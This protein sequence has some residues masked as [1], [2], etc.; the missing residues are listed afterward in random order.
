LN[1]RYLVVTIDLPGYGASETG[2]EASIDYMAA[3]VLAVADALKLN[4]FSVIG[5]SMGGYVALAVTEQAPERIQKLGLFHS[6]PF[7]DSGEK[8]E[9]RTKSIEFV[10]QE[11][12]EVYVGQ[13]IPKLF[14]Q[15]FRNEQPDLLKQLIQ[16][17]AQAPAAAIL[18]SLRAMRDRPDRSEILKQADF[19]VLFIIGGKDEAIPHEYSMEQTHY[20]K[21]ADI[22]LLEDIG[23]MGQFEAPERTLRIIEAFLERK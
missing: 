9:A 6:H 5:H 17:A 19:P 10:Q 11:G 14:E 23:H 15:Q 1:D 3:A 13:L 22:H 16:R 8:K 2:L 21:I 12:H 20:P 7:A 18:Q 4:T